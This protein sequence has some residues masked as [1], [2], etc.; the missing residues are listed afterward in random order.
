MANKVVADMVCGRY[1]FFVWPI[2]F[3]VLADIVLMWPIWFVADMVA[4]RYLPMGFID[5]TVGICEIV[6]IIK[7]DVML[8]YLSNIL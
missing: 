1:G 6:I 5:T 8:C 4:P 7:N 3:L 2:W